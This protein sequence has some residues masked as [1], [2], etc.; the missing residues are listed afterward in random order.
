M[1][2]GVVY[3]LQQVN[4]EHSGRDS[5][6][7]KM[8]RKLLAKCYKAKLLSGSCLEKIARR[9]FLCECCLEK[10]A[11]RKLFREI[12]HLKFLA[13]VCRNGLLVESWSETVE[14]TMYICTMY[15]NVHC[16]WSVY[17]VHERCTLYNVYCTYI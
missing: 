11:R 6:W 4:K 13:K 15:Q 7:V 12:A 1:H 10:V 3:L 14:I 8:I 9:K 5:E 2:R 16:I 17:S